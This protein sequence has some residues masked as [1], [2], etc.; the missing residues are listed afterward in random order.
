MNHGVVAI[1]YTRDRHP[2]DH[3]SFQ[4][5]GGP[6]PAHCITDTPGF[7]F[8]PA[9]TIA[10]H[11]LLIDK[12]TRADADAYSGFDG[13]NLANALR[14]R[15]V[16]RCLVAGLA[17]DYCVK[18][19]ALDALQAGWETWVLTDAIAA[20]NVN[21][22]DDDRA[23]LT[24]R[25]QGAH[26]SDCGQILALLHAS[27]LPTALIVV[28][29]QNDFCPGGALPV[30]DAPRIFAPLHRLLHKLDPQIPPDIAA[31]H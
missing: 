21:P 26:L 17:T 15:G 29:V 27:H 6:W 20:V 8:P 12:A 24:M 5:Q 14:E 22:G 1:V 2:T 7:E 11:A 30:A 23:L 19:T 28:D 4:A 3:C 18:A 10:P 31:H 16:R 9:L 13:T 25:A